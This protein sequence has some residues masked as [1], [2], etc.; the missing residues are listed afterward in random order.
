MTMHIINSF[1]DLRSWVEDHMSENATHDEIN[2]VAEIL[3]DDTARPAWGE[4]FNDYLDSLPMLHTY[5]DGSVTHAK[6]N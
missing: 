6:T 2:Q 4:V 1:S 5:L 3:R